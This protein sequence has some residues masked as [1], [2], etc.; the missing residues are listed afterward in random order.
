MQPDGIDLEYVYVQGVSRPQSP[1]S[2]A[3][4]LPC[5]QGCT[6]STHS[7]HL[8]QQACTNGTWAERVSGHA[9][10]QHGAGM[11][12]SKQPG[13]RNALD[14]KKARSSDRPRSAHL[15][16]QTRSPS[17]LEGTDGSGRWPEGAAH[18]MRPFSAREWTGK[19]REN[20]W[21][22]S[23]KP[24]IRSGFDGSY[25]QHP[26]A[27]CRSSY[28]GAETGSPCKGSKESVHSTALDERSFGQAAFIEAHRQRWVDS[29]GAADWCNGVYS[30]PSAAGIAAATYE[31][32]LNELLRHANQCAA[33]LGSKFRYVLAPCKGKGR[34]GRGT[35][36]EVE[37]RLVTVRYEAV[38]LP[39]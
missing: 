39:L 10:M 32:P 28:T 26:G 9:C 20:P 23:N 12:Q 31:G 8:P 16:C 19:A 11:K 17:D 29:T 21:V 36:A 5:N 2:Q 37:R 3:P 30:R 33:A 35:V 15:P 7:V 38:R 6:T 22:A 24:G 1:I 34:R 13:R 18:P 27:L 4:R 14:Q 25:G